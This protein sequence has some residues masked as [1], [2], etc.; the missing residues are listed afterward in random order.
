MQQKL[1]CFLVK[2]AVTLFP[3]FW[4]MMHAYLIFSSHIVVVVY[5]CDVVVLWVSQTDSFC[6]VKCRFVH[7]V[8]CILKR[9]K[10][11]RL[12][13]IYT[14]CYILLPIVMGVLICMF[15]ASALA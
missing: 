1:L 12:Y 10:N 6:K 3:C 5:K 11:C 7:G 2:N 9:T 4:L 14:S 8:L 13:Y 15:A